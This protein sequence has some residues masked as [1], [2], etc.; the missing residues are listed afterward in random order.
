[1]IKHGPSGKRW[2]W[3]RDGLIPAGQAISET[4]PLYALILLISATG[5]HGLTISYVMLAGMVAMAAWLTRLTDLLPKRWHCARIVLSVLTALGLLVWSHLT[6]APQAAWDPSTTVTLVSRPWRVDRTVSAAMLFTAWCLGVCLWSR[7]LWIGL[8]PAEARIEARWFVGGMALLLLLVA[9]V[10]AAKGPEAAPIAQSLRL[11]VLTYFF[12]ALLVLALVHAGTLSGTGGPAPGASVPW[13]LA[14]AVPI[15]AVPLVGLFLTVGVA[16]A[17]RLTMWAA[18]DIALLAW[19]VTLWVG[20]WI[21]LFLAWLSSLFPAWRAGPLHGGGVVP[22]PPAP[23]RLPG[24]SPHFS[25]PSFDATIIVIALAAAVLLALL[26]W[27]L[28]RQSATVEVA[29]SDEERSSAWSWTLF[30]SQLRALWDALWQRQN[31]RIKPHAGAAPRPTIIAAADELDVRA[32]Y[33]RFQQRA[34]E[35][36]C[37]RLPTATPVEF[38]RTLLR[39]APARAPDIGMVTEVYDR[40]RYGSKA[41][42][43][44][45]K[46]T[47][48]DAVQRWEGHGVVPAQPKDAAP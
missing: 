15:A 24:I 7:G 13:L 40:A 32:L 1:M 8:Q 47:M 17:I 35:L 28:T 44:D 19:R 20:Y 16:P 2:F 25:G 5:Q 42:A 4:I 39:F 18:V 48:R 10:S 33:R 43:P 29:V 22:R 30:L 3:L 34:A 26:A 27:L 12:F 36:R 38:A 45:Q 37:P 6:L 46:T 41:V 9:V 14:V 11:L 23:V 21:L 31:L